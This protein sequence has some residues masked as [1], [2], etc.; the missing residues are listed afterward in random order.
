MAKEEQNEDENNLLKSEAFEQ[1]TP[2]PLRLAQPSWLASKT[3]TTQDEATRVALGNGICGIPT[4]TTRGSR[5]R[6]S[7]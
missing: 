7:R 6:R 5:K 3:K 4:I 1:S 2:A